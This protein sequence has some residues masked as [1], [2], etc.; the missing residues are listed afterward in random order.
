MAEVGVGSINIRLKSK[1]GFPM[2]GT[3]SDPDPRLLH[4][5]LVLPCY[6]DFDSASLLINEI[7]SLIVS[8]FSCD[9]FI[10]NDCPSAGT[11]SLLHD[12]TDQ[13][14]RSWLKR[15]SVIELY[16]NV[17]QQAAIAIGVSHCLSSSL[18]DYSWIAV[19]DADGEDR[20]HALPELLSRLKST[21]A[22]LAKRGRR[23]ESKGFL[24]AYRIYQSLFWAGTG[25]WPD[26]G[27]YMI[28]SRSAAFEVFSDPSSWIH[29][30]S[31]VIKR[32]QDIDKVTVDRGARFFGASRMGFSKL[33]FLAIS[34][35]TIQSEKVIAR[36]LLFSGAVWLLSLAAI[37]YLAF[38]K[39]FLASPLGWATILS[40]QLLSFSSLLS[41]GLISVCFLVALARARRSP[42]PLEEHT[43]YISRVLK[44]LS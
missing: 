24:V 6:R 8:G 2:P 27:N 28:L 43:K 19:M 14:S 29:L 9:V 37:L 12:L 25:D 32:I 18:V 1:T 16:A 40:M 33:V 44:V 17:G 5:A 22:V 13:L 38:K 42:S 35:I 23:L 31:T 7:S 20:P 26:F 15:L 30:A 41:V 21:T 10:V 36:L 34:A 4:G 39:V 3:S 11:P